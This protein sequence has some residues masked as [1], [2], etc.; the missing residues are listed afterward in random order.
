MIWTTTPWTIPAN[1]AI[2]LKDDFIYAAVKIDG[3][4]L[5]VAKEMLDYCLDAF[6]FRGKKYEILDEFKG[7]VL[8]GA[9]CRHPLVER[10]SLLI[11]APF[12]TLEAGT[13]CVHI[14]PGHGQEDYEIGLEY[15]LENYAPVD[16]AGK[17]TADVKYFAGQFVFDANDAVIKKLAEF[18]ALLGHVPLQHSYPHCWRCKKP[19]IFRSTEQ[20]FISMEKNDLR[21]KTL[22][23]IDKVKWIPSWG[24]DRIYGMVENRPDWCISRQRLWG[25]PITVFYCAKCKKEVL[26]KEIIDYLVSLVE[27]SGADIWFEKAA[28]ELLPPGT[29]CPY[30]K[31]AEFS[32]ETNILDVWFDSGVSHAAVLEKR[33]YLKSPADIYLEGSDQ[34]RGWFQLSL[35][36][37]LGAEGVEPFK[38]VLTHGFTVDAEGKKQSKSL[39]NYV[40]A[41]EE[42]GKYG[43]DILRL[44]VASVNYQEDMRCSDTLIGRLQDA[45]RKIRNTIRYLLGNTNDFDPGK[46]SVPYD[47]MFDIDR[48]AV[49][50]LEKLIEEVT[51]AYDNF[52]FHRVYG[53]IY[54]FCVVEMSSIYMDVLKDRLYCDAKDSLSR[55]SSQTAMY[56]ILDAI[57]KLLAPVLAHTAE[58]I[59]EAMPVKSETAESVHML[60]MPEPDKSIDWRKEESK[61][62]KLMQLRDEVLR[63]LE[64]LRKNEIIA[65]N[66]ESSVTIS[67]DDAELI[68]V[69]EKFGSKNFAALCIVS[70]ININNHKTDKLIT[71]QK[72]PHQKCGRCW[73]YWPSVGKNPESPDLCERCSDVIS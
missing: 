60:K 28:G 58:E 38:T 8:E 53:L 45:Y 37:A 13:G 24:H 1:L 73:N 47:K 11:L 23:E 15:G 33:S 62:E 29:C 19:I 41:Q 57:T 20:W 18:G 6:G 67:T 25:V 51:D 9:K 36:P 4:V 39:G 46:N 7:S 43:S 61:W 14:A 34:H 12:V 22:A 50:Q 42:I 48:W 17:F 59:Y 44:W 71:A 30:C 35:L 54:N 66:Q 52:L 69:V 49:Q 70:E 3:E 64:N 26:T 65:S 40:N 32:K 5:I 72:S 27:K 55:R 63:E 56:K 16:D 31:H 21:R 68:S 10:E 2:A